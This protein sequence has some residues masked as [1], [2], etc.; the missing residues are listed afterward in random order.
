MEQLMQRVRAMID[1]S[2]QR[3]QRELA[4]RISQFATEEHTQH[5]A[6]MLRIQQNL[7]QQQDEVMNYLV[8]TAGGA[9]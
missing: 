2:E 6:D 8:R 1:Q 7:G 5:Q 9:K 3:Q 4:L